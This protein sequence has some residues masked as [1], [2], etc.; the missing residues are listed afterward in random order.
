M[1][2]LALEKRREEESRGARLRRRKL[3]M[4]VKGP[5][6]SMFLQ[7]P[8][9][10]FKGSFIKYLVVVDRRSADVYKRIMNVIVHGI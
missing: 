4:E 9:K 10:N 1:V 6:K 7:K 2:P 3:R 8:Q 5:P